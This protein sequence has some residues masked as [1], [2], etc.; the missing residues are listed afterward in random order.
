LMSAVLVGLD[1]CLDL[2]SF[3]G[4]LKSK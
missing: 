4:L 2:T 3:V 1:Y